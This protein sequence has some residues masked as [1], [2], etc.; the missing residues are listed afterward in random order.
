MRKVTIV[1]AAALALA[2]SGCGMFDH[3]SQQG[4]YA[5]PSGAT[6]APSPAGAQ[7]TAS[8]VNGS[9][10]VNQQRSAYKPQSTASNST[11]G[12]DMNDASSEEV[13]DVQ[14]QLKNAGF[15]RGS[16]DGIDGLQTHNA[17]LLF[18]KSKGL[19][20]TGKLDQQT[21]DALAGN[22]T[23]GSNSNVTPSGSGTPATQAAS[24]SGGKTGEPNTFDT[25]NGGT[26]RGAA[27][28]P[29]Q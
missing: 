21:R 2:L 11:Q 9:S 10:S 13:R 16:I 23:Q 12:G 26:P 29:Q 28:A 25:G 3:N 19:Q 15:Y 6:A 17:V 4:T 1:S 22:G 8:G 24:P 14:Q 20:Q 27:S 5:N 7:S 18:Q